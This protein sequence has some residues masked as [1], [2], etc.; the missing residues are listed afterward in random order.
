[1][2]WSYNANQ[3]YL[4]PD[5]KGQIHGGHHGKAARGD[6]HHEHL[7]EEPQVLVVKQVESS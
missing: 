4:L 6:H 1:M 5:S 3:G 7:G 2:A